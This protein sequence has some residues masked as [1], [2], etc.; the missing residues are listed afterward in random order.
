[1]PPSSGWY[2]TTALHGVTTQKTSTLHRRENPKVRN[3]THLTL[4][5]LGRY[6]YSP[7]TSAEVKNAW[8]CTSTPPI[9]LHGVVLS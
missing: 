3:Y 2:P 4:F 1:M 5:L 9:R 8:R 7:A 6:S